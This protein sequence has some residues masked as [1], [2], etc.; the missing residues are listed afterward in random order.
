MYFFKI[1]MSRINHLH[2]KFS[3]YPSEPPGRGQLGATIVCVLDLDLVI[4]GRGRGAGAVGGRSL[5]GVFQGLFPWLSLGQ[6]R[7]ACSH[8]VSGQ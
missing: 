3:T 5:S 4:L 8:L 6:L 1:Q 7:G 2:F